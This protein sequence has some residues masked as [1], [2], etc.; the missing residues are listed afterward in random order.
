[1]VEYG[2]ELELELDRDRTHHIDSAE[3]FLARWRHDSAAV[4]VVAPRMW[5][6]IALSGTGS[7]TILDEPKA[8][9]M[10]KA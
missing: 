10:V 4:A 7:R 2:G 8:I 3:T 5:D 1:M 6:R 9:V